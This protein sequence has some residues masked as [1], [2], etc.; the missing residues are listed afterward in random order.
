MSKYQEEI[1]MSKF[2]LNY[3]IFCFL[4]RNK[5]SAIVTQPKQTSVLS[6]ILSDAQKM[7]EN[8]KCN[9]PL[10]SMSSNKIEQSKIESSETCK[11]NL[12]L[13][14]ACL[15]P[16]W[17]LTFRPLLMGISCVCCCVISLTCETSGNDTCGENCITD[18]SIYLKNAC[19]PCHDCRG[20]HF[21]WCDW[22]DEC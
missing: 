8:T 7:D 13:Y 17:E 14:F 2:E 4:V 10:R 11:P 12:C 16:V 19:K 1:F 6:S 15:G 20:K 22:T 5:M 18:M 21:T 9:P 3:F